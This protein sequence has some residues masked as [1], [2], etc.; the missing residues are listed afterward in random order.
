MRNKN[1]MSQKYVGN[2]YRNENRTLRYSKECKANKRKSH[3]DYD[4]KTE[5]AENLK[6]QRIRTENLET[7]KMRQNPEKHISQSQVHT[8][9]KIC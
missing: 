5:K 7:G 9:N 8:R 4:V 3:A 6:K 2:S 1:Y